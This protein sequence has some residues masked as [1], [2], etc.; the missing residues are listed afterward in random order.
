MPFPIGFRK[1]SWQDSNAEIQSKGCFPFIFDIF[2]AVIFPIADS[3]SQTHYIPF[4]G[5]LQISSAQRFFHKALSTIL[6]FAKRMIVIRSEPKETALQINAAADTRMTDLKVMIIEDRSAGNEISSQFG[7]I[8]E[9]DVAI[10]AFFLFNPRP[11][12][13][14]RLSE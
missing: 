10:N 1:D 6:N 13:G 7:A 11:E 12:H 4:K 14:T 2:S 5:E 3:A 9:T 8:D